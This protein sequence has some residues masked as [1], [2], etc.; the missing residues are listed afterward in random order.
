MNNNCCLHPVEISTEAMPYRS[1]TGLVALAITIAAHGQIA[2]LDTLPFRLA[3]VQTLVNAGPKFIRLTGTGFTLFNEDL[4]EFATT[5]FPSPP[6]GYN[7]LTTN[8]PY[9][10][11]ESLF[12]TDPGTIEFAIVIQNSNF[13]SMTGW[14][15]L[16]IDGTV[17]LDDL[18]HGLTGWNG[19]GPFGTST[20]IMNTPQ[21]TRMV[22]SS[23]YTNGPQ[24]CVVYSLPGSLPCL[25]CSDEVQGW[26]GDNMAPA[27]GGGGLEAYPNPTHSAATIV[28][29]MPQGIQEGWLL[30]FTQEGREVLRI[31]VNGSGSRTINT[32]QLAPATYVCQLTTRNGPVGAQRLMVIK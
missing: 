3:T 20:P 32:D 6:S 9:Y 8:V 25:P 21:G 22:L 26:N 11:T 13:P 27:P 19:P 4:S 17:L 18:G 12:D 7:Y 10:L 14:R 16:R 2:A 29:T 23:T 5:T 24:E 30:F 31:P 15:V 1:L 28:Y